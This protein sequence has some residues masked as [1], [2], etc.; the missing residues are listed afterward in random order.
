MAALLRGTP[1]EARR[2]AESL[3]SAAAV[4]R[5]GGMPDRAGALEKQAA[6]IDR[7]LDGG[8]AGGGEEAARE[9]A[10]L[11]QEIEDMMRRVAQLR[12]RLRALEGK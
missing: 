9:A 2:R 11:R 1:D 12:E 8:Q 3:R 6:A 4:L 7:A 5:D 10:A